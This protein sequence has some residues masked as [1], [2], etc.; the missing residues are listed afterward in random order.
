LPGQKPLVFE[1]AQ[2]TPDMVSSHSAA[3][4]YP[5]GQEMDPLP[6]QDRNGTEAPTS[7]SAM[8]LRGPSVLIT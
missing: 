5:F 6:R 2:R 8:A 7:F 4:G 3:A 1:A